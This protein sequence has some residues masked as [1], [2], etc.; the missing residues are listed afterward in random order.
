MTGRLLPLAAALAVAGCAEPA[1][2]ASAA[3]APGSDAAVGSPESADPAAEAGAHGGDAP[4][5]AVRYACAGGLAFTLTP[6][7]GGA[8][9]EVA[10]PDR[11]VTLARTDASMGVRYGEG[12]VEVWIADAGAFVAEAGEMTL[13]DCA[14]APPP[15]GGAPA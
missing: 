6:L 5:A 3:D 1:A 14:P 11:T 2:D 8:E 4:T 15:S 10:L 9:A 7:G 13:R 12:D